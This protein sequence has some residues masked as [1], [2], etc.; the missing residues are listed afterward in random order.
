MNIQI[1]PSEF[2]DVQPMRDLYRE[3]ANCQI[4][5]DSLLGRG[6]AEP[7]LILVDG[8]P[9]GYGGV[10]KAEAEAPLLEFY[11]TPT[12]RPAARRIF[13]ELLL[14]SGVESVE[15]QTNM[16]LLLNLMLDFTTEVAETA[17]LF[18]DA[19]V[20]TL[21][22]PGGVLRPITPEL[23]ESVFEHRSE[24]VG[25]LGLEIDGEIVGTAGAYYHYNPPYGDVH[26]EVQ[27]AFRRRGVGSYLIQEVKRACYERG[28]KP[29]A[30]CNP[31]NYAS[32][33]TLEK[34]GFRVC[35]RILRGRV[36]VKD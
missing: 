3:Q 1:L 20:S 7:Y 35:G 11:V 25:D 30:R 22:C 32:R 13:R 6:L 27:E 8:R 26:M 12:V 29:G 5:R 15:A 24:P 10:R 28:K 34:A 9:A 33:A 16:P 36:D 14:V 18:E 23:K 31:S 17:I 2:K 21:E 19:F 4:V